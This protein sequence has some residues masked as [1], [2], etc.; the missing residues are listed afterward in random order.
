[1]PTTQLY[2]L[3]DELFHLAPWQWM[4]EDQLIGLSHPVTGELA[5]ISIM[6][7]NGEH[8]CLALY[9]GEDALHRF[10]TL[11]QELP[12]DR[13][14]SQEDVTALILES[15]QLQVSFDTRHPLSKTDLA[16]IKK[17][18][19]KYRGGNYPQF[20]SLQPGRTPTYINDAE[21]EWL[22]HALTQIQEV[23]P[24]LRTG[25]MEH[26]RTGPQGLESLTRVYEGAAWRTLWKLTDMRQY[27]FPTPE[28]DATLLEKVA[29]HPTKKH[30]EC[31]FQL[32]P[33]PIGASPETSVYVFSLLIVDRKSGFVFGV[34]IL[35]VEK[36]TY[37]EMIASVPNH[38][39]RVC[40]QHKIRP[41]SLHVATMTTH[42]LLEKSATAFSIPL[43]ME[44]ELPA[45]Q[46][47]L[48]SV[49]KFMRGGER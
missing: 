34:E 33:I 14:L 9:L 25:L 26:Q 1:M 31:Q 16:E 38:F 32:L 18:G 45:L 41:T 4:H 30:L 42:A 10:N 35:S 43:E 7:A 21:A 36:Q 24:L 27:V 44:E 47:A 37:A 39:L 6:G 5:Q 19:R 28:S 49:M 29:R 48:S 15:R 13:E 3:A 20:R 46:N 40:D 17:L 12:N 22:V 23:A 2:D 8:L 11:H